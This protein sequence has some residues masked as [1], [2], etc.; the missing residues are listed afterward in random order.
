QNLNNYQSRHQEFIKNPKAD[1]YDVIGYARKSPANL[2][3]DVLDAI[4]KK[5]I[6]CLQSHSQVTDV[7]VSPNSRS[8]SPITSRDSTD[9]Q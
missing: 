2:R 7:Y 3:D 9:E 1:G 8:K 5:M 4:I 6:I